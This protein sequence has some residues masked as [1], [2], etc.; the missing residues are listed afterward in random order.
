M[1]P[2]QRPPNQGTPG[3]QPGHPGQGPRPQIGQQAGQ[4]PMNGMP[5]MISYSVRG[6]S[7]F[8][9]GMSP[10]MNPPTSIQGG[11][12]PPNQMGHH[13]NYPRP[14]MAYQQIRP[15]IFQTTATTGI[16]TQ[17]RFITSQQSLRP[18]HFQSVSVR[19]PAPPDLS[20]DPEYNSKIIR[21]IFGIP[22]YRD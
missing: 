3:Q 10:H 6:Q 17:Q 22:S 2:P 18:P 1:N 8:Q 20:L 7:G 16:P 9:G 21:L 5:P 14:Q 4:P 12:F 13:G 11:N 19:Y 15:P